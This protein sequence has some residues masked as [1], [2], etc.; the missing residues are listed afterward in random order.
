[1]IAWMLLLLQ[2]SVVTPQPEEIPGSRPF[3]YK[4]TPQGDLR[5]HVFSPAESPEKSPAIV[6][7]SAEA[8]GEAR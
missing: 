7:S 8:G 1:M 4:E 2:S 3:V 6:F 5:L